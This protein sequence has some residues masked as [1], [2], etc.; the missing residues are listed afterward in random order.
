MVMKHT[1]LCL[2]WNQT[3][4]A[5]TV[6]EEGPVCAAFGFPAWLSCTLPVITGDGTARVLCWDKS[7]GSGLAGC[8]WWASPWDRWS[9]R[10][11]RPELCGPDSDP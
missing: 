1:L 2:L 9:P 5:S 3:P 4:G 7:R 8:A 6:A 10:P 11:V